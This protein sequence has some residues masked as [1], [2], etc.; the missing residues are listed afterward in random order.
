[1]CCRIGHW[2]E[3]EGGKEGRR[4]TEKVK[5]ERE[6]EARKANCSKITFLRPPKAE[7]T[8]MPFRMKRRKSAV[9]MQSKCGC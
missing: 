4:G 1:M 8:E 6:G 2:G 3:R 5:R 7:R 9:R